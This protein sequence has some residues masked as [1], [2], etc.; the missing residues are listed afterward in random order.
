MQVFGSPMDARMLGVNY[1][2]T[3]YLPRVQKYAKLVILGVCNSGSLTC[4]GCDVNQNAG[5]S[6]SPRDSFFYPRTQ[7]WPCIIYATMSSTL[8][9]PRAP[10]HKVLLFRETIWLGG[11]HDGYPLVPLLEY[12]K[13]RRGTTPMS[14]LEKA[15]ETQCHLTFGLLEG[16]L[17]IKIPESTM[18]RQN[19]HG[20]TVM[21]SDNL[22]KVLQDCRN[23]IR[24]LGTGEESKQW[25]IR[26]Q[27]TLKTA[28]VLLMREVTDSATSVIRSLSRT[29]PY[30][31]DTILC[32]ISSIAEAL[33]STMRSFPI[34]PYADMSWSVFGT[35]VDAKGISSSMMANGWCPFTL[36]A[37]N[38]RVCVK[39]YMST[40]K[41]YIR[42]TSAEHAECT[43][44]SCAQNTIDTSNYTAKHAAP[45]CECG[46]SKP[47]LEDIIGFL[48]T[49]KIPVIQVST[50]LGGEFTIVSGSDSSQTPYVA[51]SHVWADG[52]GSTT[53]EGLP[54]CQIK[55][56]AT[57]T[58]QVVPGGAFW[59]D[60][61]CV[62]SKRDMRKRAIGL[63]AQ[64]YRDAAVVLVVDSGIRSCSLSAPLSEKLLRVASSGWMQRLWTLQEAML[65]QKLIF[66][67]S[68]GLLAADKLIPSGE[69]NFN[70]VL[71][72]LAIELHRLIQTRL[73]S[74]LTSDYYSAE[75]CLGDVSRALKF[76]TS[77][78]LEDE[79][80]AISGLL[81]IDAFELVNLCPERRMETFLLR[82]QKLPANVIFISGAKLRRPGFRW[83]SASLM[84]RVGASV[85]SAKSLYTATCTPTGLISEYAVILFPEIHINGEENWFFHNR[86]KECYYKTIDFT[87]DP[88]VTAYSFNALIVDQRLPMTFDAIKAAAVLITAPDV[89][90]NGT[91][92]KETRF[93]C[94]FKKAL[95]LA[96]ISEAQV[97][98]ERGPGEMAQ[99]R[100]GM[101]RM[102]VT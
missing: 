76:R 30:L 98:R 14:V 46:Y 45:V 40:C 13:V 75:L 88:S 55:R 21:H 4:I 93:V 3:F 34:L 86:T 87:G 36:Q 48:S 100:S 37:L 8:G 42:E 57:M 58:S 23:R 27:D 74:S 10:G 47:A 1:C 61:L 12:P 32:L 6:A 99:A 96:H 56:L 51:I 5:G 94:E 9:V 24:R 68:D 80:L 91:D 20:E 52:L 85:S 65:A 66:E 15:R 25:G 44:Y 28:R 71:M 50:P 41:P 101:M 72:D 53:E 83:A 70:P 62:P 63:M 39:G 102:R 17:E 43:P 7:V 84:Q 18:L 26:M 2:S 82:I 95:V 11:K 90:E 60:A 81:N 33:T 38:G 89:G 78:R 49:G 29:Q 35:I 22:H 54:T 73:Y 77:S 64:T 31:T 69:D 16:A 92:N 67:F 79:T 59:M 97:T 19:D